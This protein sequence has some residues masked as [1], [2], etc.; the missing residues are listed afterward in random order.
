MAELD[1]DIT[2]QHSLGAFDHFY[3]TSEVGCDKHHVAHGFHAPMDATAFE[4]DAQHEGVTAFAELPANLH[5]YVQAYLE[6]AGVW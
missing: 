6:A 5:P 3:D 2:I 1:A 4:S